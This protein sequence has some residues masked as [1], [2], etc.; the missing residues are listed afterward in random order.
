[1]LTN[2]FDTPILFIVF[3]RP[4][5]ADKVFEEIRSIRPKRLFVAADG[6]RSNQPGEKEKCDLV[7]KITLRID[8]ECELKTLFRE[9]NLGCKK[10]VSSA[11]DWFFEHVEEGIILE[12]DCL[13]DL[14]FFRFCQE[15][16]EIY[17]DD[18]R[19]PG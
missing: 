1:M 3:N 4:D 18:K 15:L 14:S 2:K 10:A 9:S 17:R 6:P 8:W 19:Q 13:P 7:Q 12:D 16:L 5:C 11:I